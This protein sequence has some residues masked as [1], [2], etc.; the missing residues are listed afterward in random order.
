M[1]AS[2]QSETSALAVRSASA[3]ALLMDDASMQ[4]LERLS[5]L[6][7]AGKVTVPQHLRGSAGDCFAIALQSMQW[8]MNPFAV[9]QKTFLVSGVLGY[10]AQLVAAVIN[11]SGAVQDRFHFEWFGEWTKIV[12]KFKEVESRTK[13]DDNGHPKKYIVP[14]WQQ[15]DEHGLGVRVWAT[16]KGEAEPRVLE[17]LM[18]QARTRNS[19]LWTEDPKQQ[20][21]YLAQKRW[22]RLF[23]PDVIL[24]VYTPD[25]LG[26]PAERF[27][28]MAEVVGAPPPPP[29]PAAPEAWPDEAFKAR[30]P[31]WQK[32]VDNGSGPDEII[33]FAE[34]KGL[35]SEDQKAAIRALKPTA[36]AT[37]KVTYAQVAD[38][39]RLATNLDQLATAA[40]LIGEVSDPEQ[41][42]ELTAQHDARHFDLS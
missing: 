19:T 30:M 2:T 24:G 36:V 16:I 26:E 18:T 37:V 34:S 22:A 20:I 6:M 38:G 7:A 12:G 29:P 10:E 21:A 41:R 4:R 1:N 23:T 27:M 14:A 3:G 11:S 33:S 15:A 39:I 25:E 28:G 9:A 8:G 42:K 31:K 13:K 17:I 40:D 32:A 35:L 5:D